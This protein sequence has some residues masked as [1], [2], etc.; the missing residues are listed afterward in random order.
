MFDDVKEANVDKTIDT[1]SSWLVTVET[2]KQA[3][4]Y[5]DAIVEARENLEALQAEFQDMVAQKRTEMEAREA[6]LAENAELIREARAEAA[7]IVED[8]RA[9]AQTLIEATSKQCKRDRAETRA[10]LEAAK[11]LYSGKV[12]VAAEQMEAVS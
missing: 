3:L 12:A 2:L 8:G 6:V 5:Q 11:K 9:A 7:K 1:L 10:R 4:R